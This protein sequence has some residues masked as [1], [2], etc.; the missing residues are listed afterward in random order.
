MKKTTQYCIALLAAG[1][2][3]WPATGYSQNSFESS[4][5][6]QL[7]SLFVLPGGAPQSAAGTYTRPKNSVGLF[8]SS[9][10]QSVMSPTGWGGYG[11]ALF[12]SIGGAYPEVYRDNKAD[13]IVSGGGCIGNPIKA[14]NVAVGV[15]MVDVHRF[16]DFSGNFI[17]SRMLFK[18]TSLAVGGMQLFANSHQS[19]APGQT[20]FIA[21]SHAVQTLESETPGT[22]RLSY[23]VGIGSGRFLKKSP[24]DIEN[25]RGKYGTAVFGS[26]SYELYTHINVIAEWTGMNLG[27]AVGARPF[28]NLLSIG[29]GVANL[30]RYSADKPNIVFTLGYPLSFTK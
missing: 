30:T 29:V 13:L 5:K 8:P 1:A 23:T 20:Y 6:N 15:N 27:F 11:T 4:L 17:I 9:A 14:V 22:S 18:G 19:D 7:D 24:K 12:G 26:V 3:F 21:V 16:S 28:K 10:P 2:A 25:G